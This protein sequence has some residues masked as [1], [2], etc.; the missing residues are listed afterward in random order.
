M[1]VVDYD[2][3][4]VLPSNCDLIELP[5]KIDITVSCSHPYEFVNITAAITYQNTIVLPFRMYWLEYTGVPA[6]YCRSYDYIDIL[7][8]YACKV[9][10]SIVIHHE[11]YDRTILTIAEIGH[12]AP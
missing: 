12:N 6:L 11:W 9:E 5:R 7:Y 10:D 2:K 4:R 8:R 3:I 1:T